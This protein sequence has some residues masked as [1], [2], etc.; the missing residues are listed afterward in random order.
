MIVPE[1]ATTA[2]CCVIRYFMFFYLERIWNFTRIPNAAMLI[3]FYM[4]LKI[5]FNSNQRERE[6]EMVVF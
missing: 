6:R 3:A 4:K 1:D 2:I 5:L